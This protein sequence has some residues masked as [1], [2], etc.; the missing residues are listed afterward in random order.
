MFCGRTWIVLLKLSQNG[1]FWSYRPR[2]YLQ[3]MLKALVYF[4][5]EGQILCNYEKY[6]KLKGT[7]EITCTAEIM[8]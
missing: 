8:S 3:I 4:I 6:D 2:T 5:I 7:S 1:Q